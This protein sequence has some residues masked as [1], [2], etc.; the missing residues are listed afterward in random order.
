M[1]SLYTDEG[2]KASWI[3]TARSHVLRVIENCWRKIQL[4]HAQDFSIWDSVD[5]TSLHDARKDFAD[6]LQS[7]YT[8]IGSQLLTMFVQLAL[9][10]LQTASYAELEASLYC[11]SALADCVPDEGDSDAIMGQLFG[12]NLF[13]VLTSNPVSAYLSANYHLV[14]LSDNIDIIDIERQDTTVSDNCDTAYR[15]LR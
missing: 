3:R 6:I 2:E 10:A 15:S 13:G 11:L 1:C 8:L 9:Q 5:R 7:S 12:S 4:P 14:H